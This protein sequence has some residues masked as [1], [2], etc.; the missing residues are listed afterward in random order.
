MTFKDFFFDKQFNEITT[1][2][3][4]NGFPKHKEQSIAEHSHLVTVFTRIICETLK[5]DTQ[6][7]LEC[8]EYAMFHDYDE[9]F[10]GDIR[11][12]FKYNKFNGLELRTTINEYVIEASKQKLDDG[13]EI[14]NLLLRLITADVPVYCR[15]VVKLA[16]WYAM[17]FYLISEEK[18]GNRNVYS[19]LEYCLEATRSHIK[20]YFR[21]YSDVVV[22]QLMADFIQINK[23]KFSYDSN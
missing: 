8:C 2:K 4:W 7:T 3:S 20:N 16:D 5:I 23:R 22:V 13:S 18:L 10:S 19:S 17:L 6:R 15:N 9:S 12:P 14:G 21:E 1:I 11:H